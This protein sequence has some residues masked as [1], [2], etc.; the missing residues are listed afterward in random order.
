MPTPYIDVWNAGTSSW[1]AVDIA[2][3]GIA[4]ITITVNYDAPRV[5]KFSAEKAQHLLSVGGVSD[6]KFIRV[7]S[8]DY[9]GGG[10]LGVD[11]VFE[12]RVALEPG[13]ETIGI[14]FSGMDPTAY[15]RPLMTYGWELD[16][17]V[18]VPVTGGIPRVVWNAKQDTD[19]DYVFQRDYNK[20]V[21]EIIQQILDDQLVALREEFAA[22]AAAVAYTIGDLTP[23]DTIPQEKVVFDT[24]GP[25]S[26]V[27]RLLQ[28]FYPTHRLIWEPGTRKW[29]VKDLKAA[30]EVTITLNKPDATHVVLSHQLHRSTED[31][32]TAVEIYGPPAWQQ[33]DDLHAHP[34][35]YSQLNG[36]ITAGATSITVDDGSVFPATPPRFTVIIEDE[37]V[38]VTSRSGNVLTVLA[39]MHDHDDNTRVSLT[40]EQTLLN[41]GLTDLSGTTYKLEEWGAGVSVYGMWKLQITDTEKRRVLRRLADAYPVPTPGATYGNPT[42]GFDIITTNFETALSP[43]LLVKWEANNMGDGH[44]QALDG[45]EYD[46]NTGIIYFGSATRPLFL[47]R[48]NP[49]PPLVSGVTGPHCE[50]PVDVKFCFC[51][52]VDPLSVRYPTSGYSGTAY[53][54][55]GIERTLIKH[56][57]MLSLDHERSPLLTNTDRIDQFTALAQ[58]L[59]EQYCDNV[60]GGGLT[61]SGMKW[62]DFLNLDKRINVEA[63]D[64]DAVA[65]NLGA[66]ET[67]G[68]WV[69][70][71]EFDFSDANGGTT[72]LVLNNDQLEIMGLD[73]EKLKAKLKIRPLVPVYVNVPFVRYTPKA[74]PK[75]DLSTAPNTGGFDFRSGIQRQFVGWRDPSL[76]GGGA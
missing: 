16:G 54:D 20:T 17:G 67:A 42:D 35:I 12:G 75:P 73:V 72:T 66:W 64:A 1:D 30:T 29:R 47:Y 15:S 50:T 60:F 18:A 55:S 14:Q 46:A 23:L 52:P 22:P 76:D 51:S 71:A 33:W 9:D 28:E 26:A 56:D 36:A 13:S 40:A 25:R 4:D 39:T 5:V 32:F 61:I 10:G 8:S 34:T 2:A 57:P 62:T 37:I 58:Q 31:R 59:H 63:V 19:D 7:R 48:Y 68:A 69:T 6:F 53:S 65:I 74:T 38:V 24:E 11:P 41:G 3:A 49:N 70:E 44:W 43:V 45:F 27:T 21:G